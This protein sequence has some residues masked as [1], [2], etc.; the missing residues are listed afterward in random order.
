MS[1]ERRQFPRFRIDQSIKLSLGREEYIEVE[2]L[3]LGLGGIRCRSRQALEPLTRLYLMIR[4]AAAADA[5]LLRT[6]AS[7]VHVHKVDGGYEYGVQ[8]DPLTP[9]DHAALAAYLEGLV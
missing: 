9:E 3:D 2:G 1:V 6:E 4:L 8:F 7:V 5:R